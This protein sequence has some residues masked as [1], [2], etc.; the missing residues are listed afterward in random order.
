MLKIKIENDGK[1]IKFELSEENVKKFID[2][3]SECISKPQNKP[4]IMVNNTII[5]SS[6]LSNSVITL[7]E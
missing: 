7:G 1:L 2:E 6:F 5:G 4:F 3:M